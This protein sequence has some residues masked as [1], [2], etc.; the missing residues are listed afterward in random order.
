[1]SA[2]LAV[3]DRITIRSAGCRRHI[4]RAGSP[5]TSPADAAR[6]AGGAG[7]GIAAG[8]KAAEQT[9]QVM[10]WA[11]YSRKSRREKDAGSPQTVKG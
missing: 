10:S 2:K 9:G 6:L 3:K 7:A 8:K 1:M 5:A 4:T 11:R